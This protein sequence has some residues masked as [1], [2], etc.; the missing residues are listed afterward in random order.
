MIVEGG[1]QVI[2]GRILGVEWWKMRK[3]SESSVEERQ[4][5]NMKEETKREEE[6]ERRLVP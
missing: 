5:R 6:V 4:K 3:Q 1:K 2:T